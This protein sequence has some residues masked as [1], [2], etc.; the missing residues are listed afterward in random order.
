VTEDRTY[1]TDLLPGFVLPLPKLLAL[2]DQW[3]RKNVRPKPPRKPNP[4][5]GG[6][7]G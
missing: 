3:E 7:D 1:Q 4:P 6:T 5:A 2:A